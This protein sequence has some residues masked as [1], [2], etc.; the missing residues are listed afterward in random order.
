M[1]YIRIGC[2]LLGHHRFALRLR[3]ATASYS[4]QPAGLLVR[5]VARSHCAICPYCLV[6]FRRTNIRIPK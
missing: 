6:L 4:P 3:H 5:G 2:I 1:R